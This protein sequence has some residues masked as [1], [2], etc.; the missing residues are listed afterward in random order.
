MSKVTRC[1]LL[2]KDSSWD[3]SAASAIRLRDRHDR[4]FAKRFRRLTVFRWKCWGG[5]A[6]ATAKRAVEMFIDSE[7]LTGPS[8]MA[9][10]EDAIR[11][12]DP[13]Y[14]NVPVTESDRDRIFNN[15]RE[16]FR[17]Q[18]FEIDVI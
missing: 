13:P 10:Y 3:K 14:Q 4:I 2:C 1:E 15:I 16:A 5:Q 8:G 12:G 11:K 7:V 17:S 18:G 6:F 9:V